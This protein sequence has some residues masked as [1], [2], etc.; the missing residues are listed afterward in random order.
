MGK[1]APCQAER[2]A[3]GCSELWPGTGCALAALGGLAGSWGRVNPGAFPGNYCW[4]DLRM[5]LSPYQREMITSYKK[6][7]MLQNE[8]ML[9]CC[10]PDVP[11]PSLG[12]MMEG[13]QLSATKRRKPPQTPNLN[14]IPTPPAHNLPA[15]LTAAWRNQWSASLARGG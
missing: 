2:V 8:S 6:L 11:I 9:S 4:P 12:G 13:F 15:D 5:L 10:S 3:K 7:M 14:P 1:W